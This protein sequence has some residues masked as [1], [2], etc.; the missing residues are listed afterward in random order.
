MFTVQFT[1]EELNALSQLLDLATKQGGLL[2]A[3]A[4]VVLNKKLQAATPV[5]VVD[6]ATK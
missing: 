2:V 6:D 1:K 4:A 5:E 3:E